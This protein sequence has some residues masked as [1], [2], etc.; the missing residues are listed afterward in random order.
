VI[1]WKSVLNLDVCELF[2][3]DNMP[4]VDTID[5]NQSRMFVKSCELS[6]LCLEYEHCLSNG[7]PFSGGKFGSIV[8]P[9][10]ECFLCVPLADWFLYSFHKINLKSLRLALSKSFHT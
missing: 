4:L 8:F 1:C 10:P 5:Y 2:E 3:N 7:G 9:L 6:G